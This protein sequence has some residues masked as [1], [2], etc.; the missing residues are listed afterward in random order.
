MCTPTGGLFSSCHIRSECLY[1]HKGSYALAI[2]CIQTG[3]LLYTGQSMYFWVCIQ[4]T[5][6][7]CN[8]HRVYTDKRASMHYPMLVFIQKGFS[9]LA[10]ALIHTGRLLWSYHSF[11]FLYIMVDFSAMSRKCMKTFGLLCTV[12][13]VYAHNMAH[14]HSPMFVFMQEGSSTLAME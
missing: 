11:F 4:T 1:R 3:W 6:L 13:R 2:L 14:L 12:R 5:G 8:G 10:R 7:I 9:T